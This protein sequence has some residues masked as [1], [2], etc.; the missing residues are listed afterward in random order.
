LF[1]IT[2]S[3]ADDIRDFQIE[4]MSIGDSL[5]DYYSEKFILEN[6]ADEQYKLKKFYDV[7]ILNPDTFN[8]YIG[9]QIAI[10]TNDTKYIIHGID[11]ILLYQNNIE[12]CY[13]DKKKIIKELLTIF[14]NAKRNDRKKIE[15]PDHPNS[16]TSD[17]FLSLGSGDKIVISCYDWSKEIESEG[18]DDQLRVSLW[19]KELND[20]L[21]R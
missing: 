18:T 14:K 3:Q 5:L 1:L 20:W 11:G 6:I 13:K 9:A 12:K 19:T 10:K 4:G 7:N 8:T 17:T 2:P 16:F 15:H 21:V